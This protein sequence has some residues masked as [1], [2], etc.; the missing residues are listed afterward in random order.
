[1]LVDE[2]KERVMSRPHRDSKCSEDLAA[3]G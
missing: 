2:C 1:M 3:D